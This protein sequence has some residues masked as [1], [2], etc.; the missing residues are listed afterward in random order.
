[1]VLCTLATCQVS[2]RRSLRDR[3]F[4]FI[5]LLCASQRLHLDALLSEADEG[6][7]NINCVSQTRTP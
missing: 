6:L 3:G 1:M 7:W 2:L 5:N 4:A